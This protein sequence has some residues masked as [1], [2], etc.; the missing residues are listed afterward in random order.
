[1]LSDINA[2]PAIDFDD[3][4]ME[5]KLSISYKEDLALCG[6]TST[7]YT[8]TVIGSTGRNEVKDASAS[9][10]LRL[11]NPCIDSSYVTIETP[12]DPLKERTYELAY[13]EH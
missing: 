8:V 10:T 7:D 13:P 5:R 9:F 2:Q 11:K 4:P 1:M 12:I 6:L 3:D